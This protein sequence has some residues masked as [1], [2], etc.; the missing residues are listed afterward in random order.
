MLRSSRKYAFYKRGVI[1]DFAKFMEKHKC[2]S[3]FLIKLSLQF[4]LKKTPA[5]TFS[6]EFFEISKGNFFVKHF[7]VT[8]SECWQLEKSSWLLVENITFQLFQLS[9]F[10]W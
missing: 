10:E 9:R 5:H 3:L 8:T 2:W 7:P 1:Q 6:C 4:Y